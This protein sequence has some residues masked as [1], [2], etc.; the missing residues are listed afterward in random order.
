MPTNNFSTYL[1]YADLQMAAEAIFQASFTSGFISI[2]DLTLGNGRTSRFTPTQATQFVDDW[3]VVDHE[4]NTST[5]F[6]G[7]LFECLR[8]DP[9]RGLVRGQLV[10]CFRSTE[11]ADDAARDNQATN[12]MEI[13]E[14]GWAFG[15]IADMQA[16]YT[17]LA[18]TGKIPAGAPFDVT[19]YSLGGHLATAF[20][21]LY[22]G[23][24][25][26]TY[27]FNGA[28][29]GEIANGSLSQT[30]AQ[31][32]SLRNADQQSSF[33][34]AVARDYYGRWRAELN[35]GA[36]TT[37][38]GQALGELTSLQVTLSANPTANATALSELDLLKQAVGRGSRV[39]IEAERIN[40]GVSS[41]S[42]NSAPAGLV[43]ATTASI[44]AIGLDY[45]LAVLRSS[46]N[47]RAFSSG[48]LD[49]LGLAIAAD[50][51]PQT[52]AG[53]SPIYDLY[54]AP[55]PSAVSNSQRH[56]GTPV[57]VY[58]EDQP[59]T[60]GNFIGTTALGSLRFGEVKLLNP[61]FAVN[62]FGDT[63]SLVLIVDSLN[64]QS[65]LSRLDAAVQ[66]ATLDTVLRNA[67]NARG[68]SLLFT[69]GTAE[70]DPLE[71]VVQALGD[72]TGAS[73]TAGWKAFNPNPSGGTWA[74]REDDGS[75]TGRDTFHA[76]LAKVME[77]IG[78]STALAGRLRVVATHD[79]Q[80][81]HDD[82]AALL[83]LTS[84]ATFS[85]RLIDTSPVSTAL[86]AL[87]A[88]NG[89]AYDQW[90]ADRTTISA[91]GAG[92][93]LNLTDEYLLDRTT[94]LNTLARRNA[95]DSTN[96]LVTTTSAPTDRVLDFAYADT[97]SGQSSTLALINST[98]V[99]RDLSARHQFI[100][101]GDDQANTLNGSA[102]QLGDHLYAGAGNDTLNGLAGADWLE[103]NVGDDTL[104]GGLDNDTLL[105]GAG[106]DTYK[107]SGNF[108]DDIINDRDGVIR[109]DGVALPALQRVGARVYEDSA[110]T[111]T[112]TLVD[113]RPGQ[114]DLLITFAQSSGH[115]GQSIRLRNWHPGDLGITPNE[116]VA[117]IATA[118]TIAGD[119]L[120]NNLYPLLGDTGTLF[121]LGGNDRLSGRIDGVAGQ[122][123]PPMDYAA[124]SDVL[125]GGDG[126]DYIRGGEGHD[127]LI[128][129]AGDDYMIGGTWEYEP[130]FW[131]AFGFDES[132]PAPFIEASFGPNRREPD[133]N[134]MEGGDGV[135]TLEGGWGDDIASGGNGNDYI[136]G[137]VGND[138]IF[139][140][141]GDDSLFGDGSN[142]YHMGQAYWDAIN[143]SL[144]L[145][146]TPVADAYNRFYTPAYL[147]GQ[148]FIDGG[149][150]NDLI[151]GGGNDDVLMGGDGN[152]SIRGDTDFSSSAL[153]RELAEPYES[154]GDDWLEGGTGADSLVGD[155]GDDVLLGGTD[156]DA[157]WGDDV[158]SY[159]PGQY[160]GNDFLDG[161]EG[162]DQL[163]G[164]GNDDNLFGGE[165][166]DTL[167]GD[168]ATANVS[169]GFH[170]ADWLEGGTGADTLYGDGGNDT[171]IGGAG[172]DYLNGDA[173]ESEVALQFHGNDT[174]EGGDGNDTL[175]GGGGNDVLIGGAGAD[176]MSGGLG[177]DR[178]VIA[179]SDATAGGAADTI[180]ATAGADSI[181]LQGVDIAS[182][183]VEQ[184][185]NGA[186]LSLAWGVGQGIF[187]DRGLTS[188]VQTV[189][190]N[191]VSISLQQLVA[192]HL[193]TPVTLSSAAD[194]GRMLGGAVADT[195]NVTNAGNIIYGGRGADVISLNTSLG[196]TARMSV[197]DGTDTVSAVRRALPATA[198]DPAPANALELG[199]GIGGAQLRLYRVGAQAWV[200]A[201][202]DSGDGVRFNAP[203]GTGVPIAAQDLPFDVIRL[204]DGN[205]VTWQQ[206]FD[207]GVATL[208]TATNGDDVLLLTPIA[209]SIS[210][211]GGNDRIEGLAGN[212]ILSG[213]DGND[214]LL[215]GVGDDTLYGDKGSNFLDGGEGNDILNGSA[216]LAYD[217]SEGGE[218]NDQYSFLFGYQNYV[219]GAA[220]DR[221]TTSNDI[222]RVQATSQVGG[223]DLDT[224]T[225][226]DYGGTDQLTLQASI[227]G[228][229]TPTVQFDGSVLAL[230]WWNLRVNFAGLL[231]S[232]GMLMPS[233]TIEQVRYQGGA[234]WSTDQL[235]AM[236]QVTTSAADV[237][238]S[239][240][241]N[242]TID[243]LGGDDR[244]YGGNGN[245]T[246]RGGAG[247]D[248]LYGEAGDDTLEAGSG[249]GVLDGGA[250]ND[251]Y[252]ARAGDGPV[253]IVSAG[254]QGY[255][256]LQ[257]AANPDAV[258]VTVVRSTSSEPAV[259]SLVV[260]WLDGSAD[261]NMALLGTQPGRV[262]AVE[263][264]RFADGTSIDVAQFVAAAGPVPTAGDDALQM[265][266]LNDVVHAGDGADVVYGRYGDDWLDGGNS[267]DF[268]DG[269]YGN[270]RLDGGSGNDSLNG[271]IGNDVLAGGSGSDTL[272]GGQGVNT[273]AFSAGDGHDT[274]YGDQNGS[275]TLLLGTGLNIAGTA[276]RWQPSV[277]FTSLYFQDG[278]Y[279]GNWAGSGS[280]GGI[281]LLAMG[282]PGD[283]VAV[284][285]SGTP[286]YSVNAISSVQDANGG[287]LGLA[288]LMA[289]ANAAT[290]GND[291]IL[292][293]DGA[294][295]LAGGDGDDRIVGL[296]GLNVLQG[297]GG[298]DIL[299]GGDDNDVLNGGAG[300]DQLSGAHGTNV[301][302]YARGDGNDSVQLGYGGE[303]ILEL[304]AGITPL[305]LTFTSDGYRNTARIL[306]GGSITFTPGVSFPGAGVY[307]LPVEV[308][309]TDGTVWNR[310]Q[311][312]ARIFG[313]TPGDDQIFGFDARNDT[314]YGGDGNDILNGNGGS[315]ALDG[316]AGNDTL[317]G[318]SRG[319]QAKLTC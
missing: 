278:S 84:G 285:Y 151:S 138:S 74:V 31:F 168:D 132:N 184:L 85:L 153:V 191:G 238:H 228:A 200:L 139:G 219:S 307:D 217:V 142:T 81:A 51:A 49:G 143:A 59:L 47:T 57:P 108:G 226:T 246:L 203:P 52:L 62:D 259:D 180:F 188:S 28:G 292:D 125:D 14:S 243:G 182:L 114:Q 222:Y 144:G 67:S 11:F 172:A 195:F 75:Y 300:D 193:L 269:G 60:R 268:L 232:S 218:G 63:H 149:A 5:G 181:E 118:T 157:L 215:G 189:V 32:Q 2:D 110:R 7:T 113:V 271:G 301:I 101:F 20:N 137:R 135:D 127:L 221:S 80:A 165:G 250:G 145:P 216:S 239:I 77:K 83:S 160:H 251:T 252:V 316:G 117:P 315:D 183:V 196:A 3:K 240:G 147:V 34:T 48:I 229:P 87:G 234:V 276:A 136:I 38:R 71:R 265:T 201:F 164:G 205:T 284:S 289:M 19:G 187:I 78:D 25:R 313:G 255:D 299:S 27:T 70:F 254:E 116:Q 230:S 197:G 92:T 241:T 263:E 88:S 294:N 21:L 9:A 154:R 36:D 33:T 211:L 128:G 185:P 120:E 140:D 13:K 198:G 12:V 146:S 210:G 64:V 261:V 56:Y 273:Y 319:A 44:A 279:A 170:G 317:Y 155:A 82:F 293:V 40:A 37:R 61:G 274:A 237:I 105:G 106:T 93:A 192:E 236:T 104:D 163:V 190:A 272:R 39:R 53:A 286:Y 314:I 98:A 22:P 288:A 1:N 262:D 23:A 297:Q 134:V 298:N 99:N 30:M 86:V 233:R 225:I 206:I 158:Q 6:S 4:R 302:Q 277:S 260:H 130:G 90:L 179:A 244:L 227:I 204:S 46:A 29:V 156:N 242:D 275:N 58:I 194:D 295:T 303:T 124:L 66:P 8:D 214:T 287:S 296:G 311:L 209:D 177:D 220:T 248:Q 141:A 126:D 282:T 41:G 247:S 121:G 305:D 152:D 167:R 94:L 249:G 173:D 68:S 72:I 171:L 45:Q 213:G 304:G 223:G 69:Q 112:A 176:A 235:L 89:A 26:S 97:L 17:R 16:W 76:N 231:D 122:G 54:G 18:S 73:K 91:G 199:A 166:N 102:N 65:A 267:N 212:D 178:Y 115:A 290:P 100:V 306:G 309:F 43:A 253:T 161:E 35:G 283:D 42:S 202:N 308:R 148:D 123:F 270:D 258:T 266:S 129:G 15:Q 291:V 111:L 245:D 256:V 162:D 119:A 79:A 103:G 169:G 224:W 159:L 109:V 174:L 175:I 55:L 96:A 312:I 150:G 318:G 186:P 133:W 50:R 95:G 257:V 264:I 310:E 281:L 280:W 10:V 107:F 207:R 208:P 131:T 24:A